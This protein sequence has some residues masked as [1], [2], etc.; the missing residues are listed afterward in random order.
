MIRLAKEAELLE[1]LSIT[2]ACTIHMIDQGIYQWKDN[3]HSID[4]YLDQS[5]VLYKP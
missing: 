3:L 1:I 5:Y 4:R 2:K